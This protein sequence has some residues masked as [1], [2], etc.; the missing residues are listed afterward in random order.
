MIIYEFSGNNILRDSKASDFIS[1][2]QEEA[3]KLGQTVFQNV[4]DSFKQK[5]MKMIHGRKHENF[6]VQHGIQWI[7]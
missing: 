5:K 6:M 4:I 1:N 7:P 2:P 3:T